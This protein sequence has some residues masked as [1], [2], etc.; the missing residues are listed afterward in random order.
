MNRNIK[1]AGGFFLA[2]AIMCVMLSGCGGSSAGDGGTKISVSN[3]PTSNDK[4]NLELYEGYLAQMNEKYPDIKVVPDTWQ[5]DVNSFLPKAASGQLPTVFQTYFTESKKIIGAGYARDITDELKEAGYETLYNDVY[6]DLLRKDG[7]SYGIV[8]NGYVMGLLCNVKLFE[9]AGLVDVDGVPIFP[10]T[11]DE[12]RATAKTIKEKT[13]KTGFYMPTI[14]NQGGWIF[15]N[16]AWGFGAEF[17]KQEN[18]K[19]VA[20]F[21]SDECYEAL[22]YIRDMKWEDNSLQDDILGDASNNFI[23]MYASDQAAMGIQAPSTINSAIKQYGMDKD[24]AAVARIPEGPAMRAALLG[25][26]VYMFSAKATSEEVK[27]AFKWL[28]ITGAIPTKSEETTSAWADAA[29][30]AAEEGRI[31]GYG[32]INVFSDEEL[33]K[34][35][36]E[37]ERP[38]VTVDPK[39]FMDYQGLED[40]TVRPEPEVNAQELYSVFDRILQQILTDENA[41]IKTILSKEAV[42][43]QTKYMDNQ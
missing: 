11:F 3:W 40:V 42:D 22:K 1:K 12:L 4:V 38:Y 29:K 5:Y 25:G 17:E 16:I 27:A 18:G 23:R 33:T 24:N 28:E 37:A 32:M 30:K 21:D 15:C 39:K 43:F 14:N 8:K 9:E 13:G 35:K 31:V 36:E 41:D 19:W 10:K 7:R 26:G 6:M 20:A 34:A 2:C